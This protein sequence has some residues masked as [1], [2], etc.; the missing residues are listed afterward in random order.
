[1]QNYEALKKR[2]AG[3]QQSVCQPDFSGEQEALTEVLG[4]VDHLAELVGSKGPTDIVYSL[5]Q[6]GVC[7]PEKLDYSESNGRHI[8]PW[9]TKNQACFNAAVHEIICSRPGLM[10][11][12]RRVLRDDLKVTDYSDEEMKKAYVESY[13]SDEGFIPT[14]GYGKI[15]LHSYARDLLQNFLVSDSSWCRLGEAQAAI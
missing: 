5:V 6:L 14:G 15:V 9:F 8:D 11:K 3:L 13:G 12:L 1:M 7:D 4:W 10:V 2:L